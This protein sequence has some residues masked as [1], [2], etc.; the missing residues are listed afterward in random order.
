MKLLIGAFKDISVSFK[1]VLAQDTL[2][3]HCVG[4]SGWTGTLGALFSISGKRAKAGEVY[5]HRH[6]VDFPVWLP[7][8]TWCQLSLVPKE[9]LDMLAHSTLFPIPVPINPI[10]LRCPHTPHCKLVSIH[11]HELV[12]I[13]MFI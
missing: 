3:L 9:L 5:G 10:T 7:P 1:Q 13:A 2:P 11:I 6:Q 4:L 12:I 8:C